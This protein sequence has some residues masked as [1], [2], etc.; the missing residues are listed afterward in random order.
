MQSLPTFNTKHVKTP[1]SQ[2]SITLESTYLPKIMALLFST[3]PAV[4]TF[5]RLFRYECSLRITKK[6]STHCWQQGRQH[7][8]PQWK[9]RCLRRILSATA[10]LR[11]FIPQT[12]QKNLSAALSRRK[13]AVVRRGNVS[14]VCSKHWAT[15]FSFCCGKVVAWELSSC[16]VH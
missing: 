11:W 4:I 8:T 3:K 10:V 5:A 15:C 7:F 14:Q 12:R 1:I 16:F 6:K 2:C 9:L 13:A